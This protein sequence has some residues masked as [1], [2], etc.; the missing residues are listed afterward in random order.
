AAE[1]ARGQ[2]DEHAARLHALDRLGGDQQRG[3]PARYLRGGDDDVEAGDLRGQLGLL[4]G[5]LP[6]GERPGVPA[7]ALGWRDRG[8]PQEPGPDR[9]D[10]LTGLRTDVVTG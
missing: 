4:G 3:A 2:V 6:G 10:L 5:L 9:L 1:P 8:E 7:F